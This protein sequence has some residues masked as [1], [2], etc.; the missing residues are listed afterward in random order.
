MIDARRWV[1]V[2]AW[3][4]LGLRI[5]WAPYYVDKEQWQ[6]GSDGER[7]FY[8]GRGQWL[9]Q[10]RGARYSMRTDPATLSVETMTHELAH[11]MVSTPE[12]RE[13]KNFGL[14]PTSTEEEERA[15]EAEKVIE[16]LVAGCNRIAELALKGT[17]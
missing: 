8:E 9:I 11:Y 2:E 16:A 6:E 13:Q 5:S 4:A 10:D 7:Y 17:R 14:T 15:V 1:V 12:Q 3:L